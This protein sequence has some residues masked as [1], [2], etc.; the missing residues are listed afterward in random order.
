[1]CVASPGMFK[2][3]CKLSFRSR[4]AARFARMGAG[5][6]SRGATIRPRV[7]GQWRPGRN[8]SIT[9]AICSRERG[10]RVVPRALFVSSR[11]TPWKVSE[12]W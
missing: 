4:L 7:V 10:Q 9:L 6:A 2:L 5:L 1:M 8:K 12:Y 3:S 11:F